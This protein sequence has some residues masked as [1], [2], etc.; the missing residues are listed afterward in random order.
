LEDWWVHLLQANVIASAVAAMV[1]LA[2]RRRLYAVEKLTVGASPL[3]AVQTALGPVATAILLIPALFA[4]AWTPGRLPPW[5]GQV[6]GPA[7]WA[8][9]ALVAV[10]AAWYLR[11]FSPRGLMHVAAG[12]GLGAGTLAA[13]FSEKWN[14]GTPW[15]DWLAYHVLE[16]AWA[17]V[18][19]TVLGLGLFARNWRAAGQ[20]EPAS[21]EDASQ[22]VFPSTLMQ[23]WVTWIGAAVV[24]LALLHAKGDPAAPWW[25]VGAILAVS[26]CAGILA[27]ALRLAVYVVISGLLI[28]VAGTVMWLVWGPW[29][30]YALVEFYVVCLAIA[31]GIWSVVGLAYRPGPKKGTVPFFGPSLVAHAAAELAVVLVAILAAILV[32]HDI[33]L[34]PHPAADRLAWLALSATAVALGI[35]LWDRTAGFVL[36]GLYALGL[37]TLGLSWD[38]RELVARRLAWASGWELAGFALVAAL[39]GLILPRVR[40]VWRALGIPLDRKQTAAGWFPAA[41]AAAVGVAAALAA[42][43]SID[44]GFDAVTQPVLA[45]PA[46][47]MAGLAASIL[48]L[49][50]AGTMA[51]ATGNRWRT[52]WQY[53]ALGLGVLLFAAPGWALLQ[54]KW[55]DLGMHRSVVLMVAAVIMALASGFGLERIVSIGSDWVAAGS[56]AFPALAALALLVLVATLG[57]EFYHYVPDKG[58][59]MALPAVVIVAAALAGLVVGCLACAVAPRLDP[60]GLSDHGRTVYVYAAEAILLVIGV[61]LRL[62]VPHLFHLAIVAKYWM[63]LL[64][65]VAFAGAGLSEWFH[66]RGQAVLSEPLE[67]TAMLVP[68]VPAIGF[69]FVPEFQ[70][71]EQWLLA[72]RSPA[73]WFLAAIFYGFLAAT[74]RGAWQTG[75]FTLLSLAAANVGLSVMWYQIGREFFWEHPQVWLIPIGL[76]I[77]LAEYFNRDGLTPA[78]SAGIRYLALCVIYIPSSAEYLQNLQKIGESIWRPLVLILLSLVGVLAGIVLRIRSF[79]YLGVTF[80]ALVIVTMVRYAAVDLQKTWVLYLCCIFLGAVTIALVALYEKRRD[81][82]LAAIK[83]FRAWQK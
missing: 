34:M 35:C 82:I 79:L 66:R 7:G 27:M 67:R 18:G 51:A 42:W 13:C 24:G 80:L 28:N 75:V 45:W 60:F 63:L 70:G 26:L 31:S 71:H 52:A 6:A 69:W 39:V 19:L 17:I 1:W 4:I 48:L 9:L 36:P 38:A 64:M 40:P 32:V 23:A 81:A 20:G 65:A 54:P 22:P 73:V 29:N 12:L 62:T 10:S 77:L 78:Q 33:Q 56:R 15:G 47:R 37:A 8:A 41:Q 49:P 61:H 83:Q 46:G 5:I 76:S 30:P 16:S 74:R 11:R 57:Q 44:L 25:S 59:P 14:L 3:L 43:I 2:A 55:G 21:L 58:A 50:A 53:I 72:G 68:L